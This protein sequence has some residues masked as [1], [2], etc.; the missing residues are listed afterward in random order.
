MVKFT[1]HSEQVPKNLA[2]RQVY[3]VLFVPDGRILLRREKGV[4]QLTGGKPEK[5]ESPD[6]VL[7][8]EVA[9]E[10]NC[11]IGPAHYVGYQEVDDGEEKYAQL[12]YVALVKEIGP[13]RADTDRPCWIYGRELV[14]IAHA[15]K[16]LPYGDIAEELIDAALKVALAHNMI[17]Q[18]NLPDEVLNEEKLED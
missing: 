13:S 15:K 11:Q 17:S 18:Q 10:I 9:E 4:Y 12:R 3:G 2:I 8:R 6:V 5:W 7:K 16:Y 14:S 1:W